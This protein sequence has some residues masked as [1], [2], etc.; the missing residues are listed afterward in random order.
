MT[1]QS[2]EHFSGGDVPQHDLLTSITNR[3]HAVV[4]GNR[5]RLELLDAVGH[6]S[7]F[8]T[9]ATQIT[10]RYGTPKAYAVLVP[11]SEDF[12]VRGKSCKLG[13]TRNRWS[14]PK[15]RDLNQRLCVDNRHYATR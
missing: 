4:G 3:E 9:G 2:R 5:N 10:L 13:A 14:L 6:V 8:L 7:I 11:V 12:S 15:R 1:L